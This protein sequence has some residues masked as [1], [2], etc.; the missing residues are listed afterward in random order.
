MTGVDQKS[1]QRVK[2]AEW[3]TC[4]ESYS[5]GRVEGQGTDERVG[6]FC[7]ATGRTGHS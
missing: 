6:V 2:L 7:R 1:F 4:S 5:V 3:R